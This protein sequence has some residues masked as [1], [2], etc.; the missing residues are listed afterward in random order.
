MATLYATAGHVYKESLKVDPVKVLLTLLLVVPFILGWMAR[1]VWV[2]VALLWTGTALGWRTAA[3]QIEA[4]QVD[5]RL[6][7]ARGS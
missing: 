4:R 6:A 3:G 1:I 2:L 7:A 5:A